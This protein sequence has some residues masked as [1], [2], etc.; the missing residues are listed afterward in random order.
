M[1]STIAWLLF[2]ILTPWVILFLERRVSFLNR[3]GPV[4]LCY[5][6]G[7]IMANTGI[8]TPALEPLQNQ[9]VEASIALA[10]PLLF[11]SIDIK[12]WVQMAGKSALSILFALVAVIISVTASFLIFG[13]AV[14][15][16]S[17]KVGGMLIGCYTGG[18][19]NLAAI[20]TALAVDPTLYITTHTAD[21]VVG[22]IFLLLAIT[23]LKPLLLHI[24]PDGAVTSGGEE[25]ESGDFSIRF[26]L[27]GWSEWGRLGLMFLLSAV[28]VGVSLGA[29]QLLPK[30]GRTAG[31]ILLI[32]TL[33]VLASLVK[34]V[35]E[36][37][38][39]FSLGYYIIL[40][41]SVAVS[42]LANLFKLMNTGPSIVGFVALSVFGAVLIHSI[43]SALARIDTDTHIITSIALVM[44]PPFVPMVAAS[45]KNRQIMITGIMAGVIGWVI[46]NYAGIGFA[47][48]LRIIFM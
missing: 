16:E 37:R 18:T 9:V 21:F 20:G 19:P 35:R 5:I 26:N 46:G 30:G 48:L 6:A 15:D 3:L 43:L 13:Q 44:S 47:H 4:V 12:S 38:G 36:T 22:A 39:T 34:P 7:V 32:T 8:I 1:I 23:V 10:L 27:K 14:G 40:V 25:G 24:M 2:F 45:L 11:F 17:W 42:S 41:F 29:G 28:I 31:I 33:G